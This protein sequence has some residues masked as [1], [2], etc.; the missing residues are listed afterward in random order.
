[1]KDVKNIEPTTG[2]GDPQ[3][4]PREL[5][6]MLALLCCSPPGDSSLREVLSSVR[7]WPLLCSYK[8]F[9][10]LQLSIFSRSEKVRDN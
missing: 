3:E 5:L 9:V 8:L 2:P 4:H 1:M 7:M 10:F 6:Q